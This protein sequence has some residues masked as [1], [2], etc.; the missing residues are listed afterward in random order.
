MHNSP[1]DESVENFRLSR[2]FGVFS[3]PVLCITLWRTVGLRL[4][5]KKLPTANVTLSRLMIYDGD[6]MVPYHNIGQAT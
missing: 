5:K 6:G 1:A 3:F 2:R 4:E